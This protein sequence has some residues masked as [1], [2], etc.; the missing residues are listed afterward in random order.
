[1]LLFSTYIKR[2]IM[3]KSIL[4]TAIAAFLITGCGGGFDGFKDSANNSAGDNQ[5][6]S[7]SNQDS[8]TP[9]PYD[10]PSISDS[11]K[12]EYLDAINNARASARDC[13]DKHFN[14]TTALKWNN[15]LYNAAYEHSNDMAAQ[16]YIAHDGSGE[17][18]D[19]TGIALNKHS[20]FY[21]R[22]KHN[23]YSYK[24]V[25]E[26]VAAGQPSTEDV[27]K[28]WLNSPGHCENIMDPNFTE[29]GMAHV[30]KSGTTYTHYWT[31]DFG[32]PQ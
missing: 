17:S 29:I 32:K 12:K 27:V 2:I 23:N 11:T 9:D 8:I 13:G 20:K 3:K 24:S 10:A 7:G 14:A 21:E 22:I 28:S 4:L 5:N 31:Q 30:E 16:N 18:T 25:G 26:N 15:D 1:M 19:K 6:S